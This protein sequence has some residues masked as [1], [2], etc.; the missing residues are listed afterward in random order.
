MLPTH[1]IREVNQVPLEASH[2]LICDVRT[3]TMGGSFV[4]GTPCSSC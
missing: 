3:M 2:L 1:E 4:L